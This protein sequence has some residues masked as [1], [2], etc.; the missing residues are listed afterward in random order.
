MSEEQPTQRNTTVIYARVSD[1]KKKADGER[2]QDIE[3]QVKLL[4]DYCARAGKGTPEFYKDDGKSAFTE[5]LNQ[6]PDFKRL[7]NDVRRH[8]VKEIIVEDMTRFSRNLSMGLQWLKEIAEYNATLVSVREGEL[9]IT[10]ARGWM[11]TSILL[12][13]S[14]WSSRVQSEKV[15]SG[16]KKASNLRKTIGR[17]PK[18]KGGLE[19]PPVLPM[20]SETG[21][22]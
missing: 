3:R 11:Q 7:L 12:L 17:P 2:R 15:K 18:Q 14:E 22:G 20:S 5:D 19:T 4:Q 6:R 1:D 10:S 8:F 13:F 21:L 16:M 9:E